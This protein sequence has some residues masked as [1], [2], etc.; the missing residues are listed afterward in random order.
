MSALGGPGM[1]ASLFRV[2][3][4]L[5]AAGLGKLGLGPLCWQGELAGA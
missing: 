3:M 1:V 5:E 4:G 2:P